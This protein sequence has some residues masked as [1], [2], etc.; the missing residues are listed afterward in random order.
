MGALNLPAVGLVYADTQITIYTVEKFP[1]YGPLCLPLWQAAHTGA[2]QIISSELALLETLVMP[3]RNNDTT[4]I[5]DYRNFLLHSELRLQPLTQAIL[6]EAA[7]LRATIPGLKT[8]DA[9][10]AA[11]AL[12]QGCTLFISNDAGFRRVPGLPLV[13]LDDVLAAP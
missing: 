10:H 1:D 2:L 11:T 13:L 6:Q 5:N 12:S 4:L 9:I 8:P 3:L 7:Q